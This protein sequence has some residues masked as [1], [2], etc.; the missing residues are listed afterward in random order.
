MNMTQI[1]GEV[2]FKKNRS[3]VLQDSCKFENK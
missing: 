3:L 1:I 2:I